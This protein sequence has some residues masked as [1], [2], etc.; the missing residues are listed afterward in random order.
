MSNDQRLVRVREYYETCS[1]RDRAK[2]FYPKL[3]D[4]LE[5]T[6]TWGDVRLSF[7]DVEFV[8]P[9]FLDETLVRLAEERPEIAQRVVITGLSPFAVTRLK[10]I[11]KHRG[12]SWTLQQR[13]QEGE[14]SLTA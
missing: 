7:Q 10:S 1:T 6:P 14:Y 12:L 5:D 13:S 2:K 9:S 11:L 8:S 4:R 3:V